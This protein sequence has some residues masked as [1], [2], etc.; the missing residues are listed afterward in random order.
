MI[1]ISSGVNFLAATAGKK[2]NPAAIPCCWVAKFAPFLRSAK[3][4]AV[5]SVHPIIIIV[6]QII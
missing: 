2:F 5:V 4:N 6:L 3:F 1:A